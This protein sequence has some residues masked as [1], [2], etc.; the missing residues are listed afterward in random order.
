MKRKDTQTYQML[1]HVVDFG[2]RNVNLFASDTGAKTI[3]ETLATGVE[4]LS[5]QSGAWMASKTALR[6]GRTAKDAARESLKNYLTR[7]AQLSR[8]LHSDKLQFP[9]SP[10]NQNLIDSGKGFLLEADSMKKEF[11]EHGLSATFVSDLEAAVRNLEKSIQDCRD[12]TGR[13][14]A[15]LRKWDDTL[16]ETLDALGRF[17]ILVSNALENDPAALTSY[18]IARTIRRAGGRKAAGTAAPTPD[19]VPATTDPAPVITTATV[20]AA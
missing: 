4:T 11:V 18:A 16:G 1:T 15:S 5:R 8:A 3:L 19:P 6:N 10:T 17:D 9:A 20:V 7:A 13:R 2:T 14:S 12:A